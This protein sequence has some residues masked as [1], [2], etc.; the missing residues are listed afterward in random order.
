MGPVPGAPGIDPCRSGGI[1][2]GI[3]SICVISF[4]LFVL[5]DVAPYDL[6]LTPTT[7]P[8]GYLLMQTELPR[9]RVGCIVGLVAAACSLILLTYMASYQIGGACNCCSDGTLYADEGA[10][11]NFAWMH[12]LVT[13]LMF[14]CAIVF[15]IQVKFTLAPAILLFAVML[16]LISAS[17]A[18]RCGLTAK[19]IMA[20]PD[21]YS[22]ALAKGAV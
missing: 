13:L 14:F 21:S 9:L 20:K 22:A 2:S 11:R 18:Y 10:Y 5:S 15:M 12:L 19:A 6:G 8:L 16:Q 7:M 3:A 17:L 4:N 1:I